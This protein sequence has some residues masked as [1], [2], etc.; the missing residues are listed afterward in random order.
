MTPEKKEEDSSSLTKTISVMFVGHVGEL[1]LSGASMA[2]SFAS[3]TGFSL[4]IGGGYALDTFCGQSYGAKQYHMLGIQ[5]QRAMLVLLLVCIPLACIWANAGNILVFLGQDPTISLEAGIYARYMIPS[6]FA[7]ALLQCQIRFLQSQNNV[8][9]MMFSTGFTTLIHIIICWLLV[10]KSGLGSKGAALA[11]GVSYWINVVLL[12][13]Y[14]R[15]SPLCNNKTWNGFS[16]KALQDIPTFIRIAV[17]SALMMCLEIWSFEMMVLLAGLLPNPTLETSV[18]SISLNTQTMLLMIPLGVGGAVST[19][20]SN[21]LGAGRPQA[22]RVAVGVAMSMVAIESILIATMMILGRKIW[23]YCYSREER[24][25]HYV[26]DM[27]LLL[28]ATHLCDGAQSVVNGVS[29]GC[30]WQKIGALVNF[31]AY[32]LIGIPFGIVLAFVFRVGG[33]GLWTG[34]VVAE[35]VQALILLI[36]TVC[37]NWGKEAEV[38]SARIHDSTV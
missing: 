1:A 11:S 12:A 22:A 38:A 4:L 20:V 6:I 9:H 30:G 25:V 16:T 7:Y 29:R 34:I 13:L 27:M 18:L 14:I 15:L 35:F 2:S 24:V 32:Y 31:G 21:E 26:G 17:P 36:I 33:K 23:G 10:F 8:V 37:T 28:A 3:V 5:M 19:R